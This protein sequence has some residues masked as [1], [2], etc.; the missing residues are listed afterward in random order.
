MRKFL[1]SLFVII[2]FVLYAFTK[3]SESLENISVITPTPSPSPYLNNP[4]PLP[5]KIPEVVTKSLY[6][7]GEFTGDSVDAYY[8]NVQVKAVIQNGKISDVQFLDYPHDRSTSVRIN[9]QA[10]PQLTSEAISAQS[11]NVDIISGATA[12]SEAFIQSLQSA[13][14]KAKS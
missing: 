13:L 11:A 1:L 3:R 5:T 6:K 12:T 4:S 2:T 7:D 14:N 10:T 8:G 9:S